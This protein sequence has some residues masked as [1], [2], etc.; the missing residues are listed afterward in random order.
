MT[1]SYNKTVGIVGLGMLGISIAERLL[2][3]G[4]KINIYNETKQN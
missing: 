1:L 4:I 2:S 3:Q